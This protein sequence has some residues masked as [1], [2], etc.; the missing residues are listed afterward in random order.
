MPARAP[1]VFLSKYIHLP[2]LSTHA[3]QRLRRGRILVWLLATAML[4]PGGMVFGQGTPSTLH[5]FA[6]IEGITPNSLIQAKDGLLYGTAALGGQSLACQNGSGQSI[7]CCFDAGGTPQACGTVFRVNAD[8]SITVL[9]SFSGL[10]DGGMPTGLL[11]GGDGN[12]YGTTAM[13]G[14]SVNQTS[15]C[16]DPSSGAATGCC[17]DGNGNSVGCGTIFR[18]S[19][20]A[21][22]PIGQP[23]MQTLYSFY[24]ADANNNFPNTGAFPNPLVAGAPPSSSSGATVF[25][26]SALGCSYCSN[27]NGMLF[28]LTVA[29]NG[30]AQFNALYD[31]AAAKVPLLDPNALLQGSDG[32]LYGTTQL[33]GS[34]TCMQVVAASGTSNATYY[35]C[36]DA[37]VYNPATNTIAETPFNAAPGAVNDVRTA[38][39]VQ[40]FRVAPD[41]IVRQP[42]NSLPT[43]GPW[44]FSEVPLTLAEASSG[45]IFGATP[46]VC[47]AVSTSGGNVSTSNYRASSTCSSTSSAEIYNPGTLFQLVPPSSGSTA[48]PTVN[49]L[50]TF[51]Q[52]GDG[53]GSLTGLMLGSDNNLYGSS[54][55]LIFDFA[56]T[57]TMLSKIT[58]A[59]A[60]LS[61][62]YTGLVQGQDGNFYGVTGTGGTNAVGQLFQVAPP[63]ALNAPVQLSF[64]ANP[65]NVGS[66]TVL[67]WKALNAFSLSAQQCYAFGGAPGTSWTGLQQGTVSGGAFQGS[68]S[69]TP[70]ATGSYTYALTCGGNESAA[71]TLTVNQGQLQIQATSLPTAVVGI[72]YSATLQVNGGLSPYTW[73]QTGLSD[74]LQLST[75]GAITGTPTTSGTI[76]FSVQV[77]DSE[78]TP[79]TQTANLSIVVVQPLALQAATLPQGTVGTA[80]STTLTATGGLKPYTWTL[81]SGSSL[82]AG[83]QLN[84]STGVISGTPTASGTVNFTVQVSDSESPAQT[85]NANFSITIVAAA[86]AVTASS[87]TISIA[88]AGGSGS[89]TLTFGNFTGTITVTCTGAPSESTCTAGAIAGN[90]ATL[91][92]TTTAPA[93]AALE[94][95][96]SSRLTYA[97]LLPGVGL[98]LLGA[99]RKRWSAHLGAVLLIVAAGS[100]LGCGGGGSS[101]NTTTTK[102][103]GT[104]TGTFQLTVTATSGNQSASL[105]ITLKIG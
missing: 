32:N 41:A 75:S 26:G 3:H 85:V 45:S 36:G 70:T 63:S 100:L 97:L 66:P 56:P 50:Y 29:A 47:A 33:G 86:P 48:P 59:Y 68:L 90:T 72:P 18:V 16:S 80:Y 89:T 55:N 93:T 69:I 15:A 13:G 37:F 28:S 94:F 14:A 34:S 25:Y 53:G 31:F 20:L 35:G 81:A 101:S 23:R 46:P 22:L 9:Y 83:L 74:G 4:L 1:E 27:G 8:H 54:G 76:N 98:L 44:T 42:Q 95:P 82:P 92:V 17:V 99:R 102:D 43:G 19:T 52:S 104:P 84:A 21:V 38:G 77:K 60:T 79:A 39:G 40:P 103:P 24:T 91:T 96:G 58:P 78:S 65:A 12:L 30:T 87:T 71:A 11:Q 7:G 6:S 62:S 61:A 49:T 105:P 10:T 2:L 5:S 57:S 64:S 88:S 67:T 51:T 73:S